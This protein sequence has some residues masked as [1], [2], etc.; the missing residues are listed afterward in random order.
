VA[1]PT[2][3]RPA[4]WPGQQESGPGCTVPRWPGLPR[5][6]AAGPAQRASSV[7]LTLSAHAQLK[8]LARPMVGLRRPTDEKIFTDDVAIEQRRRLTR[9][10]GPRCTRAERQQ[11]GGSHRCSMASQRRQSMGRSTADPMGSCTKSR[12]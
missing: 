1:Q 3:A 8:I 12:G 11:A 5:P 9:R 4:C 6:T 7:A 2:Q 10:A